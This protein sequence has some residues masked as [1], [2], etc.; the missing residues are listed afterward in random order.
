[1]EYNKGYVYLICD[2]NNNKF[3]IGMTKKSIEKRI[4]ELQTGN[5]N[6]LHIA[7]YHQTFYPYCV[8]NMLHKYFSDKNV[9]NEWY[10]LTMNDIASFNDVCDKIE[11]DIQVLKDNPF[12]KK[13]LH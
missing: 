8:E 11:E 1:M 12:F 9:I 5:A 4:K 13:H 7:N 3:K 6:E 2:A 10:D